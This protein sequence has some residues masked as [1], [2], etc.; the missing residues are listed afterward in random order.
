MAVIE[1]V[2]DITV[3]DLIEY[4]NIPDANGNDRD[5]LQTLLN[6]AIT[7]VK[8][9]TGQI[10][11]DRYNDFVICILVLVQDMWDT[12]ALY[13]DKA[14]INMTVKTIMDMHSINLLPNE[15]Y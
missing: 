12:R 9:Y 14:N 2:S 6:T 13:V 11:L 10:D 7:Y 1:K 4:I 15:V 8:G 5:I 3:E